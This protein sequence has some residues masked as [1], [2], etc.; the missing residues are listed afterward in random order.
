[1]SVNGAPIFGP[2]EGPG[3]DAVALHFDYFNEDRQP[4]VLGWCTGHSAGQGGY[5][6]HYDANC[7]YWE[8][9]PG[10]TMEDYDSSKIKSDEHSPIIGWAFDGYPIYGMYGYNE[11]QTSL[12]AIT[13]SYG[14]ERTQE[15]GDQ[16]YNG[17]DDWNYIDGSGDLDECNGRFG[18]TPEYPDGIYHYVSTP[19][20][21]S[22]TMVTDTNGQTVGMIGF[23]Y[24]LLC[25][26][27]VADV[28]AQNVGGGQGGGPGGGG[29]GGGGPP[30]GNAAQTLYSHMP[31]LFD[32]VEERN[33][34]HGLL[35]DT[36]WILLVLIGAAFFRGYQKKE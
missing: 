24:F 1:M 11:D 17:I 21:G 31:E 4:I 6:Y 8:P 23:P 20:S 3:G 34:L 15:G 12:K 14:I 18:P 32:S 16:G 10:E 5:H 35:W 33:N 22:P 27:G 19:L 7:V 36:T 30:G 26:H 13:S 25:Y 2:E 29:G 9:E 28:D